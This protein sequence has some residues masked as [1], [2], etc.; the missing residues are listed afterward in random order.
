MRIKKDEWMPKE[1]QKVKTQSEIETFELGRSFAK[2][3]KAG[4]AISLEGDLGTGKTAF[5]KGIAA[6]LGINK[7]ITSPTFTLVNSYIGK[8]VLNHFDVYRVDDS[9]EL[10]EIGWEEYFADDA[11]C[12]IEWGDRVLDILP[13][14]TVHVRFERDGSNP[15]SRIIY[16]ERGK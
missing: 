12:V 2:E 15:D 11:I 14:N 4:D 13:E 1:I 5:T 16:I 10:L 7:H 6:G 8:V 9:D 3:L